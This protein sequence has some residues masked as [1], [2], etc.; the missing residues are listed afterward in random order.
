MFHNWHTW[1]SDFVTIW[2][3][4][5]PIGTIPI[6]LAAVGL[7]PQPELN[8]IADQALLIAAGVLVA[9]L[10]FGQLLLGAVGVEISS[11]QVAGGIILFRFALSMLF[12]DPGS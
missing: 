6:F 5:D 7:R 3:V 12:S 1:L 11:F 4:V 2:A 10:I 9:A 8:R